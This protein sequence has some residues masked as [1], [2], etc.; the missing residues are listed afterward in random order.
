MHYRVPDTTKLATLLISQ[1]HLF[2]LVTTGI[3]RPKNVKL[4]KWKVKTRI[5]VNTLMQIVNALRWAFLCHW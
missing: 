3:L 2:L 1:K 4:L 5:M